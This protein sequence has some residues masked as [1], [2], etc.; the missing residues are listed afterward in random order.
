MH[1]ERKNWTRIPAFIYSPLT[2]A[3]LVQ[4]RRNRVGTF[5]S[6][7]KKVAFAY[8]T[9]V[10]VCAT[11]GLLSLGT[12]AEAA[13]LSSI[14]VDADSGQAISLEAPD[15][16]NYP[17]SLTKMMTLYLTFSGLESG[18]FKLD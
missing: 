14:V 13:H 5:V 9:F 7:G 2:G 10:A 8:R 18:K 15:M 16:V 3:T 17:A 12:H 6:M 11:A 4:R 1:V